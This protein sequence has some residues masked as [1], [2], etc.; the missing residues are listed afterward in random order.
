MFIDKL[1]YSS[2][3]FSQAPP[4]KVPKTIESMRVF[5]E[6]MVNPQDEEVRQ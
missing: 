5:D 2:D 6:T 3:M 1:A 4:K